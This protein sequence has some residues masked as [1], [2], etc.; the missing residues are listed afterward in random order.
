M[1]I[2]DKAKAFAHVGVTKAGRKATDAGAKGAHAA[3]DTATDA[4]SKGAAKLN[5][6]AD[7]L[8]DSSA[9]SGSQTE[10][11]DGGNAR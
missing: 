3:A 1:G 4:A 2:I 11:T 9:S 7:N 10:R 8:G 6:A 5:D